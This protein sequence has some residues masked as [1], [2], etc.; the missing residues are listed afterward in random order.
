MGMLP[1]VFLLLVLVQ[2]YSSNSDLVHRYTVPGIPGTFCELNIWYIAARGAIMRRAWH[3]VLTAVFIIQ[4]ISYEMC[5]FF[6][7]VDIQ[8]NY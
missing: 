3:M 8:H 4:T 6:L 7:P 5:V 2:D 1:F